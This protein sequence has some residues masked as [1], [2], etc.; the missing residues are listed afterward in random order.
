M[1]AEYSIIKHVKLVCLHID[2]FFLGSK[3]IRRITSNL[4]STFQ[5]RDL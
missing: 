5:E 4:Y 3:Y 2:F 1:L